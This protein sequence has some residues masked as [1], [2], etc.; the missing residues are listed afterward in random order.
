MIAATSGSVSIRDFSSIYELLAVC[1][2]YWEEL[3]PESSKSQ[4]LELEELLNKMQTQGC[5]SNRCLSLELLGSRN[6]PEDAV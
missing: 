6:A 4:K 3:E 5:M 1:S 2:G